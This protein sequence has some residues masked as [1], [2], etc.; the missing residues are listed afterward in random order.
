MTTPTIQ[1]VRVD[2]G[3][4]PKPGRWTEWVRASDRIHGWACE[5]PACE[6]PACQPADCKETN[7]QIANEEE[8]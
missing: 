3:E 5:Y 1:F 4:L 7:R 6:Y 8:L 2:L